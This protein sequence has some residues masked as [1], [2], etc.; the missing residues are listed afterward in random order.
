MIITQLASEFECNFTSIAFLSLLPQRRQVPL[1]LSSAAAV[2]VAAALSFP[3]AAFRLAAVLNAL[4]AVSVSPSIG[5]R[6]ALGLG[7]GG[8]V[9]VQ[10]LVEGVLV[11]ELVVRQRRRRW[12]EILV[13]RWCTVGSWV[14]A[15]EGGSS[16]VRRRRGVLRW[17]PDAS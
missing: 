3:A 17:N 13:H 1:S 14:W 11:V 10:L 15:V 9:H 4:G 2:N 8:L 6:R 12:I 16:A 5:F 7:G